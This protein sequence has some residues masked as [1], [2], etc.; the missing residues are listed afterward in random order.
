MPA[1]APTGPPKHAPTT[2]PATLPTPH[3]VKPS[4][5][6]TTAAADFWARSPEV[7]SYAFLDF[8][9]VSTNATTSATTPSALPA[10]FAIFPAP[11]PS[12][13]ALSKFELKAVAWLAS[14]TAVGASLQN[15][16]E[17]YA[18]SSFPPSSKLLYAP[19]CLGGYSRLFEFLRETRT[20]GASTS[21]AGFKPR[22]T[23]AG[24]KK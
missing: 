21:D 1:I 19:P 22:I 23:H 7:V 14:P 8:W 6:S 24:N 3:L 2:A 18:L 16:A 4:P 17:K 15:L 9:N 11:E 5:A 20:K 13:A 12:P 10:L